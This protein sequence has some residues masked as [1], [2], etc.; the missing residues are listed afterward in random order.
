MSSTTD[1][2]DK[3]LEAALEANNREAVPPILSEVEATMSKLY[4]SLKVFHEAAE[5]ALDHHS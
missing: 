5:R 1:I 4:E 2:A 3:K